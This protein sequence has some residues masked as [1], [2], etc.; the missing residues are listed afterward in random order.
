MRQDNISFIPSL[1][2]SL[3]QPFGCCTDTW[4]SCQEQLQDVFPCRSTEK[5]ECSGC[6][7]DLSS[8]ETAC[9]GGSGTKCSTNDPSR[10]PEPHVPPAAALCP[11][12][13]LSSSS[14]K[15]ANNPQV[16]ICWICWEGPAAMLL[17]VQAASF[18]I[19]G[20]VCLSSRCRTGRTPASMAS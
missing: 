12:L 13:T 20:F 7:K 18:W 10:P 15:G 8:S 14:T 16:M 19:T 4:Q 5:S 17:R 2:R 3:S 11:S 1:G 9:P 6:A